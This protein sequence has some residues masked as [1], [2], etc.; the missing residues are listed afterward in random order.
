M[1]AWVLHGARDIRLENRQRPTAAESSVVVRVARAG[2]C[3]SDIHYFQEGRVGSFVLK[4][5]FVLGHEFAGEV[6]ETGPGVSSLSKGDRVVVDP[7]I[8]CRVCPQCRQGRSNL[9]VSM[10]VFGSAASVPHL[11]GGFQEYVVSP[12]SCCHRLPESIDYAVGALVE[13]LA[14]AAH[15]VARSGGVAGLRVLITGAGAI[16]Q[17]VLSVARAMGAPRIAVTDPDSFARRFA[18]EH[19]A[20]QAIDPSTPDAE[21][22][23]SELAPHGFDRVF[24][25]S[26][27]PH[28]LR[29]AIQACN[30]GATLVQIGTLPIDAPVPT[31]LIM[32]KELAYLGSFRYA[33]VFDQVLD[34]IEGKRISVDHLVTHVFALDELP[35]GL[36]T[37]IRKGNS[38]KVQI[39]P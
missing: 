9:C 4:T 28:A 11:D 8:P 7:T 5:P 3:G 38:I 1:R 39:S 23:L 14:V 24:E 36:E 26:G 6:V 16:G 33:N 19:G 30:R 13:P 35:A 32:T 12:A 29:L 2:I 34:L 10:R 27:S 20:D 22:R 37:A 18:L 31:N 17:T 25:T 15:A 21:A